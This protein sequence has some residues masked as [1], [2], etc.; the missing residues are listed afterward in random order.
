MTTNLAIQVF[1]RLVFQAMLL[2]MGLI[3]AKNAY[4]CG[5]GFLDHPNCN[6]GQY[7]LT[8][9]GVFFS[10]T[11]EDAHHIRLV[12]FCDKREYSNHNSYRA[13]VFSTTLDFEKSSIKRGILRT[14]MEP[15]NYHVE[16]N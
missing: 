8:P 3:S 16:Y 2:K 4:P 7:T 12:I 1:K 9:L 6:E 11:Q 15:L 13:K 5:P 14:T 10:H